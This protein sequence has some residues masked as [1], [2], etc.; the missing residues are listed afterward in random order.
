MPKNQK[1]IILISAI[2][3]LTIAVFVFLKI[4]EEPKNKE[5]SAV[6]TKKEQGENAKNAGSQIKS[7]LIENQKDSDQDG[8]T[9]EEEKELGV[10]PNSVD[11]DSDGLFDYAE[12]NIFKTDPNNPDT[13]GDGHSDGEEVKGGYNP[14]GEGML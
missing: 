11:S 10:D 14:N 4:K 8:L 12:I 3:I 2:I 1:I 6:Q 5:P 7:V 9:D 13:D